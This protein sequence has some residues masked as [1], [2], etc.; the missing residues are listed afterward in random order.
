MTVKTIDYSF[1]QE[2]GEAWEVSEVVVVKIIGDDQ[3]IIK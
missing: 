2:A 3:A 1:L